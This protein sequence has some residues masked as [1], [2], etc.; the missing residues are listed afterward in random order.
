[1]FAKPA[2][3]AVVAVLMAFQLFLVVYCNTVVDLINNMAFNALFIYLGRKSTLF[4][5]TSQ[6]GR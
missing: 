5:P 1:M 3:I 6:Q 4:I 2:A